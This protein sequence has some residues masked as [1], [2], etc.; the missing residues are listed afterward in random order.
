MATVIVDSMYD[1]YN[2]YILLS[3][4]SHF[5]MLHARN[6]HEDKVSVYP[7]VSLYIYLCFYFFPRP[8]LAAP[9]AS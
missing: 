4:L 3:G 7:L 5:D 2:T 6:T 1:S 8:C 9:Q